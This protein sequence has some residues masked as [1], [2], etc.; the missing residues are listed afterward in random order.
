VRRAGTL[1]FLLLLA[2]CTGEPGGGGVNIA[3]D[4]PGTGGITTTIPSPPSTIPATTTT[5]TVPPMEV[6]GRVAR[7]DGTAVV[8]ATVAMGD[9]ETVTA[10]DGS[11]VI[12]T[13]DPGDMSVSKRGW[14]SAQIVWDGEALSHH[15][16]IDLQKVRGLRVSA[17]AAA[18]DAHFASLLDLAAATSVNALVF[19]TKQ[20]GGLV[21]YDTELAAAH[22]IGAVEPLYDPRARIAEAHAAGLYTITRLVAFEDSFRSGAFTEEQ[23][24]TGWLDPASPSART[25]NLDLA[26][27]ACTLG[28]DEVQ[29]DYVRY[30][31][32]RAAEVSGQREM[33]QD[34]RVSAISGFLAEARVR[35]EPLGC[36]VSAAIF[37]IVTSSPDD[38][39]LGQRPE[40]L[41]VHLDAVSPMVYPS[42]Y[43]PGWLGFDDPNAHP[44]DVTADAISD[45]VPRL[46]DGTHMRPWLQAFWWTNDQIRSSIAAAEDLGVGWIM[47]N[48]R[49]NFDAS[50]LP[51][52]AEVSP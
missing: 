20:E 51:T 36:A 1:A 3:P 5:T 38:Q 50:A 40:E 29:F 26:V 31:T 49:S 37:G 17:E 6:L 48:V 14:T 27:E 32:G 13:H 23:L 34:Q 2:A 25:Y 35:L 46:A 19:D 52:D 28:F 24:V 21:L 4:D 47:W 15:A 42:H 44:Y 43:S 12:R 16:V 30:P 45:G 18:D 9:L 8:G 10:V 11:F 33:T 22:E 41:S 7:P 39:G